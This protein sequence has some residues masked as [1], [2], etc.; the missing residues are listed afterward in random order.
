MGTAWMI[1]FKCTMNSRQASRESDE[2]RIGILW[3]SKCEQFEAFVHICVFIDIKAKGVGLLDIILL[4]KTGKA[5]EMYQ[6][7]TR[8]VCPCS[9]MRMPPL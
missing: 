1:I 9:G 2:N 5:I 3:L 8:T 7:T 4:D 6:S